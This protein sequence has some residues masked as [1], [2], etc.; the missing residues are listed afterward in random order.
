MPPRAADTEEDHRAVHNATH[1][2][3]PQSLP[4]LARPSVQWLEAELEPGG[5]RGD[6]DTAPNHDAKNW[7]P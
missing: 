6:L 1:N 7:P 2:R 4:L 5:D 3:D